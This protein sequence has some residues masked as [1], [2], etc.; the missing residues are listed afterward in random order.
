[1]ATATSFILL[2]VVSAAVAQDDNLMSE[3]SS[4]PVRLL[5][6]KELL[7]YDGSEVSVLLDFRA[8]LINTRY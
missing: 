1:M 4:R 7:R 3:S 5:T 6:E 8:S 2:I